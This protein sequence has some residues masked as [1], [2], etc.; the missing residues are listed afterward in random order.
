MRDPVSGKNMQ[1]PAPLPPFRSDHI[2]MKDAHYAEPNEKSI[3]RFLYLSWL[4][5]QFTSMSPQLC[6]QPRKNRS[7]VA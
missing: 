4:Y 5:L 1:T 3:F 2:Y 7:K 6:H